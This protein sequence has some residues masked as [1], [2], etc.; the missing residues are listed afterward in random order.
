MLVLLFI[1]IS[2]NNVKSNDGDSQNSDSKGLTDFKSDK[3]EEDNN[4]QAEKNNTAI[5]KFS[6]TKDKVADDENK[7]LKDSLKLFTNLSRFDKPTQGQLATKGFQMY[8][9]IATNRIDPKGKEVMDRESIKKYLDQKFPKGNENKVL[10]IDWEKEKF[11]N[12]K[13]KSNSK[14]FKEAEKEFIELVRYI[15]ELKPNLLVGIYGLPF[16]VFVNKY[17][18]YAKKDKFTSLFNEIDI[19]TPSLYSA[20]TDENRS[21][22]ENN[23]YLKNSIELA[24]E[25]AEKVKKPIYFFVWEMT[26][27]KQIRLLPV[28]EFERKIRI[29]SNY[30]RSNKWV[31]GIIYWTPADPSPYRI[32]LQNT[33]ASSKSEESKALESIRNNIVSEYISDAF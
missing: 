14:E 7:G 15:K 3:K 13:K 26:S 8:H 23:L 27:S 1:L 5:H 22:K 20:F 33:R 24:I 16:R 28:K 2:C 6:E 11:W 30:N 18:H 32:E 17:P 12:L 9:L 29:I 21:E 19:I 4:K 10:I 31:Q 25:Y